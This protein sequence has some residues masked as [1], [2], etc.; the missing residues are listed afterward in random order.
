MLADRYLLGDRLGTGGTATVFR[1]EDQLLQR[2]VAIKWLRPGP[3]NADSA[4]RR[5]R[6][7]A[8]ITA[9]LNHPNTV[10][11]YD[12]VV[13]G[14][15]LFLVMEYVPGQNLAQRMQEADLPATEVVA[16]LRDIGEALDHAHRRGVVH[17]DVKPA[18]ILL[19]T[20]TGRVKLAD[21]GIAF[22]TDA[23]RMTTAGAV[24]GTPAY[25]APELL[26]G[27]AATPAADI[28]SLAAVAFEALSGHPLRE[29]DAPIAIALQAVT[30]PP[31][32]LRDAQPTAPAG[33]AE[34]LSRA[35]ARDPGQ[36]PASC[37]DL[38]DALTAAYLPEKAAHLPG[39]TAD[40]PEK[41]ADHP[42][43]EADGV[44]IPAAESTERGEPARPRRPHSVSARRAAVLGACGAALVAAVLLVIFVPGS[45]PPAHRNT[46][47]P[48]RA[49]TPKTRVPASTH[50]TRTPTASPTA[51][52]T[53]PA[54]PATGP[55]TG[56]A[57]SPVAAVEQFYLRAARHDYPNA[58]ALAAP[59]F[60]QQL[61]GYDSFRATFADVL[62]I[63]FQTVQLIT[64]S[65]GTATVAIR[66]ISQQTSRTEQCAGTVMTRAAAP[67]NWLISQ[68]SIQC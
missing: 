36:R 11:L 17:R 63:R 21:L 45:A 62:A 58:W 27:R 41:A 57:S 67:N 66:T 23:S 4:A 47:P 31:K 3:E 8:R 60:R 9:S 51:S 46:A 32:D 40:R 65:G 6:R 43:K 48:K 19:D 18:N 39:E 33:A 55:A 38:V 37:R 35:L 7:E 13:D 10:Q 14:A 42:E 24:L 52:P 44:P 54:Q 15:N 59:S 26:D 25:M 34:A 22:T 68:I 56:P 61:Q 16:I 1:A 49:A 28:Y 64:S 20:H 53:R 30:T 50:G 2:A 12:A 5:F 29:G